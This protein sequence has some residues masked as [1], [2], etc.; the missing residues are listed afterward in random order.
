MRFCVPGLQA[1]GVMNI[2][3]SVIDQFRTKFTTIWNV[4]NQQ[5]LSIIEPFVTVMPGCSGETVELPY[6]GKTELQRQTQRLQKVEWDELK[7][8]K[9]RMKP[10]QFQKFLVMSTKDKLFMNK[11]ELT[12]AQLIAEQRKAAARTRD[13]VILG[14]I[15]DTNNPGEWR[16]ITQADGAVGGILAEN[17]TG[18]DGATLTP[19]N[20]AM[21]VP[22][23]FAMKGTKVP[24]GM[25]IDKMLEAKRMLE[26]NYA[27]HEGSGD[28]LCMAITPAQKAQIIAWEQSQNKNY[29]FSMLVDGKMNNMLGIQFLVTNMLPKDEQ[30]NRVCPVWV[31][32]KAVLGSWEDPEFRIDVRT[33]YID[34]VQVGVTCAY[35]ATRKDEES[36]VKVLCK[37]SEVTP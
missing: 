3:L 8:G 12:S 26:S 37:D 31:K 23:D 9:R 25:M 1:G 6:L 27:Y 34:A 17:Y 30:G 22:V 4:A 36:F 11:L 21:V 15:P 33:D 7:T 35:G 2:D 14:V 29:G 28:T 5:D 16:V 24:A 10:N 32:S 13:A 19:F 20:P 18:N